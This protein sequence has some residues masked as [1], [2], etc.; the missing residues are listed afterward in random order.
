MSIIE[1]RIS[2]KQSDSRQGSGN[3]APDQPLCEKEEENNAS[4]AG[5]SFNSKQSQQ[6]FCAF[7]LMRDQ[8]GGRARYSETKPAK[9]TP[10]NMSKIQK[11]ICCDRSI[12]GIP[13]TVLVP[14]DRLG[15]HIR[16]SHVMRAG[17]SPDDQNRDKSQG[18]KSNVAA[19]VCGL[20]DFLS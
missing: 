10:Q 14:Q 4:E 3:V 7:I 6:D 18:Q 17:E 12:I 13:D 20:R 8:P 11:R 1:K 16:V 5:K 2:R 9:R 15:I 19:F